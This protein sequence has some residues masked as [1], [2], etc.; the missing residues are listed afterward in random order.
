MPRYRAYGLDIESEIELPLPAFGG[1]TSSADIEDAGLDHRVTVVL[2]DVP[3]LATENERAPNAVEINRD[4][5]AIAWRGVGRFLVV[6]G[7]RVVVDMQHGAD[8][9]LA[10]AVVMGQCLG[11]LLHQRGLLVLHASAVSVNGRAVVF[12]GH[13]GFGK[14]TMA[15]ALQARGHLLVS[16]D[17]LAVDVGSEVPTVRVGSS[18]MRLW[19]EAVEASLG[20][21]PDE[22]PRLSE[23]I[24][25][26][27]YSA[28]AASSD[29][30]IPLAAIFVLAEGDA[31]R[32]AKLSGQQSFV[33]LVRYTYVPSL[34]QESE[35][36]RDHFKQC[37]A[38]AARTDI[39]RLERPDDLSQV[40]D[41]AAFVE[42]IVTDD[43]S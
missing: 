2:G 16:D 4:R 24:E 31:T 5:I 34:I 19:P 8:A 11:V 23:H 3:R 18:T 36:M 26:R 15:A 14:S 13:K 43:Q 32:V 10:R 27:L 1:N 28:K 37:V 12:V 38:L 30:R 39:L 42:R 41:V 25:K 6:G 9:R 22:L 20:R 29:D 17:V 7:H 40:G 35:A 33:E 21:D